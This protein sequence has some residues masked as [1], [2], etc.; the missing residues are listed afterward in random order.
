MAKNETNV[1]II[2]NTNTP[3]ST[4]FTINIAAQLPLKLM[5]MNY[6]IWKLQFQFLFIGYDLLGYIDDTKPYSPTTITANCVTSLNS[7]FS[8]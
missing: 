2:Q 5:S 1:V 8:I 6:L 3:H 7:A 4:H